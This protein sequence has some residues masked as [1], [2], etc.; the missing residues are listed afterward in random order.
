[1]AIGILHYAINNYFQCHRAQRD[2]K[3][4][5]SQNSECQKAYLYTV[6]PILERYELLL[7]CTYTLI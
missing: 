7:T 5:R 2:L 1:M 4:L 6:K 3:K